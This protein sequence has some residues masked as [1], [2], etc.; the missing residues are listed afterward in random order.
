MPVSKIKQARL[1]NMKKAREAK[2]QSQ[3]AQLVENELD[4]AMIESDFDFDYTISPV[5]LSKFETGNLFNKKSKKR[6]AADK[7]RIRENTANLKKFAPGKL[8]G[9]GSYKRKKNV[10]KTS[11]Q[12][13]RYNQ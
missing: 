11:N 8:Q 12:S 6:M 3:E 2:Q 13:L 10:N 4:N 7:K 5:F 9:T 1:T